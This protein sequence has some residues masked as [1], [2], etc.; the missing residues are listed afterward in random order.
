MPARVARARVSHRKP[1][2]PKNA[3]PAA[4]PSPT[5]TR[6]KMKKNTVRVCAKFGAQR[7]RPSLR[8]KNRSLDRRLARHVRLPPTPTLRGPF[9]KGLSD[10]G[11]TGDVSDAGTPRCWRRRHAGD[12]GEVCED[13]ED[14]GGDVGDGPGRFARYLQRFLK[15]GHGGI[16]S[17]SQGQGGRGMFGVQ[18]F[19]LACVQVMQAMLRKS[20]GCNKTR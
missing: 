4:H 16:R 10:A 17:P 1:I 9:L 3:S 8:K 15:V 13:A 14:V 11:D 18:V 19:G 12:A 2:R 7:R 20:L 6:G 5:D